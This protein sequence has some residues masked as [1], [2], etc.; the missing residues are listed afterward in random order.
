VIEHVDDVN[1][2]LAEWRRVL[3]PGGV[4]AMETPDASSPLVRRRGTRYRRFW[5]PEHTYGFT[6]DTLAEFVERADLETLALP[7]Y[8]RL[9]DLP[10]WAAC[11]AF[12]RETYLRLQRLTGRHRAF[13]VFARRPVQERVG[14]FSDPLPKAA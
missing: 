14:S 2:A 13:Q 1:A 11:Y 6:P 8:G 12:G 9:S 5:A 4:L 10:F 3:R 7:T